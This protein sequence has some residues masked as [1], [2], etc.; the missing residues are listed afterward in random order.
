[1]TD[2]NSDKSGVNA[3]NEVGVAPDARFF[4]RLGGQS[5]ADIARL[6][7]GR[8]LDVDGAR[9]LNTVSALDTATPYALAYCENPNKAGETL[10]TADA[11]AVFVPEGWDAPGELSFA[12]IFVKSPKGAFAFTAQRIVAERKL[13]AGPLIHPEA[14]IAAGAIVEPGAVIGAGVQIGAGSRIGANAVI[15]PGV[16]IGR[17]TQIGPGT[18]LQCALI[19]DDVVIAP[20]AVIGWAGFGLA[21][22]GGRQLDMPQYGRAIIQDGVSLGAGVCIDRG[23]FGDTVIGEGTKIDNMVHIAHNVVIGRNVTIAACSAMSGSVTVGDGVLMGG[24]VGIA[25]HVHIGAGSVL[26]AR[27][28]VICDIPPGEVWAGYPARPRRQWLREAA[29]VSR[30][31]RRRTD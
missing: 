29:W 11:G 22:F 26:A 8:A 18:S 9:L 2:N 27:S 20:K 28:G 23:A 10:R 24:S 21:G 7:E 6:T 31:A 13:S 30:G 4:I 16:A 19:G 15:Q 3:A 5:V 1:M 12:P 17:N 25:D 14:D